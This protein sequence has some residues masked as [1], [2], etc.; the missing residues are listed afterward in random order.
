MK[1]S[2][3][4]LIKLRNKM[5]K[6]ILKT[7]YHSGE[8]SH[9]G[10]ALSMV[11]ILA[12][13]YKKIMNI[14]LKNPKDRFILSKGHGFLGLLSILYHMKIIKTKDLKSFQRD[15]SEI[16]AHP[17][18]NSK[19]GIESSNGSLGQGLSFGIGLA[20]AYKKKNKKDCIY[21]MLGDGECYEGSVWEAAISA[22]EL[23]LDNLIV[24]VDCNGYQNDG[25]IGSMMDYSNLKKKWQGFGWNTLICDG[26]NFQKIEKALKARKKNK[27]LAIIAKTIK[28]FGVSFMEKNNDWHHG[29]LTKKIFQESIKNL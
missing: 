22:T 12:I 13:L 18:E 1:Y 3:L 25:A 2:N 23:K 17:I 14:D 8:S 7:S 28:G 20:I 21:V 5:I 15:G 11:D 26:H 24:I 19:L 27:P 10:G 29:R 9:I 16:I 4:Q 6:T